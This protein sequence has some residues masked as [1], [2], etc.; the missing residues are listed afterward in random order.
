[1]ARLAQS[2]VAVLGL[3]G[4]GSFAVEGLVR[5]GVGELTLVDFDSVCITNLNR[6]LHALTSTLGQPKVELMTER[7][8]AINPACRIHA[9]HEFFNEASADRIFSPAWQIVIDCIDNITA[10]MFLLATC[11]RRQV[12]VISCL[13]ASAK[14]DPTR[15]HTAPLVDTH[16]D[17]LGRSLR[18]FLRRRHRMTDA[19]L[20]YITA[21]FS[22]EGTVWPDRSYQGTICGQNCVCP[23]PDNKHHTCEARH[24]IHGSAVFVT[25]VFG[26]VA[27][28]EAV[29]RLTQGVQPPA[30]E[31]EAPPA[32]T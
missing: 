13:G 6:Q 19:E 16:T 4:V 29:R 28:A 1:M 32:S 2:H 11:C 21:V 27:A 30:P 7:V 9:V 8:R 17:R 24:I 12:P 3:G 18:K 31:I 22:D 20:A 10:K 25:S 26:M 15:V 23:N 14:L 5:S